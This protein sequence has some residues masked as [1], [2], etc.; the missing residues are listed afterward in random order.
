MR[1]LSLTAIIIPLL[2]ILISPFP[3]TGPA[4]VEALPNPFIHLTRWP[5]FPRLPGMTR[6][7]SRL[8]ELLRH[9]GNWSESSGGNTT[10]LLPSRANL[11]GVPMN[12]YPPGLQRLEILEILER[13]SHQRRVGKGRENHGK[14]GLQMGQDGKKDGSG[15][16]LD[17][18][19]D[20]DKED[21]D[22]IHN[23]MEKDEKNENGKNEKDDKSNKE[24]KDEKNKHKNE[25][26]EKKHK[27]HKHK[28]H[29]H[30]HHHILSNH[31]EYWANISRGIEWRNSHPD[32]YPARQVRSNCDGD[33]YGSRHDHCRFLR[34]EFCADA[35]NRF[36][37]NV[38]YFAY[39]QYGANKNSVVQNM[40]NHGCMAIYECESPQAYERAQL[41][42]REIKQ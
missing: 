23:T 9:G 42:G 12:I 6:R 26:K 24:A 4:R 31:L 35:I 29:H 37:D 15:L 39:A 30:H 1:F 10:V 27:K 7:V 21:M 3:N 33:A 36:M 17:K 32:A 13:R 14:D 18:R 5:Q 40:Q 19:R 34:P 25:K 22:E 38:T 11:F 28:H 8:A 20:P 2:V 16:N 41:T